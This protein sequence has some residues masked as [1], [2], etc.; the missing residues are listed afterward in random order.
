MKATLRIDR[1][2]KKGKNESIIWLRLFPHPFQ[3][4][5]AQKKE[6]RQRKVLVSPLFSC[7]GLEFLFFARDQAH[8]RSLG[9]LS[10]DEYVLHPVW[11]GEK[12]CAIEDTKHFS[13]EIE[14][15]GRRDV[16]QSKRASGNET[17]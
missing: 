15:I 1:P 2:E 10:P 17:V 7:F 6:H 16:E 4:G 11:P 9:F 3:S 14:G 12:E 5:L 8:S 13:L